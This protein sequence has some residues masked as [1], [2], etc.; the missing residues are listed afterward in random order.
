MTTRRTIVL[1]CGHEQ[2]AEG[3]RAEPIRMGL[4]VVCETCSLVGTV[5]IAKG[6]KP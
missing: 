2:Q 3:T 6:P 4:R 5:E 1:S